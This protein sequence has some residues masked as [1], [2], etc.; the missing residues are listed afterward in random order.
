[1][2][3]PNPE[4]T[5]NTEKLMLDIKR[6]SD[7]SSEMVELL[8][9]LSQE[10]DKSAA[11]L[12]AVQSALDSKKKELAT[13]NEI[14]MLSTSLEQRIEALRQQKENLD[15]IIAEQRSAWEKEKERRTREEKEYIDDLNA[16]RRQDEQ[17]YQKAWAAEQERGRQRLDEELR[18][19]QLEK[20]DVQATI[21]TDLQEREL[22]LKKK[23]LE[24]G[25][26]IQE[27]EQ[28]LY[29]LERRHGLHDNIHAVWP[30]GATD[31]QPGHASMGSASS[32]NMQDEPELYAAE[33][34]NG[35]DSDPEDGTIFGNG[36]EDDGVTNGSNGSILGR[37]W[38]EEPGPSLLARRDSAPLKFS[39]KRSTSPKSDV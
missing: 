16:R 36:L 12:Q 8:S 19:I 6:F 24:W 26:L 30:N 7:L 9:N 37:E 20:Q 17:D 32:T 15:H 18:A 2:E 38:E 29:K 22:L 28:F 3:N 31:E 27:L 11:G 1:V 34:E 23:E 33:G 4:S 10:I 14:E 25:Q 5:V 13:L 35:H 21:E 39:P